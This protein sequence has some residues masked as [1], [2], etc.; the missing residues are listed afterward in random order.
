M[1]LKRRNFLLFLAG[2]TSAMP[3][4][5]AS[6]YAL[7]TLLKWG[8][9]LTM[10]FTHL[11]A[12]TPAPSDPFFAFQLINDSIPLET[13]DIEPQQQIEQHSSY[14]VVNHLLLPRGEPASG[15]AGFSSPDNL[16]NNITHLWSLTDTSGG[17]SSLFG[18]NW[19]WL[20]S[21]SGF[22]AGKA[23]LFGI[24]PLK[25][26][27]TSSCF[28]PDS[29]TRLL[30][31]QYPKVVNVIRQN[32]VLEVRILAITTTKGKEFSQTRQMPFGFN[33]FSNSPNTL[34]KPDAVAIQRYCHGV[35]Q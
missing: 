22:K 35:P 21:I 34:P 2:D 12:Q 27:T 9:K 31:I 5:R 18:N 26:E 28:T 13:S 1:K 6:S 23:L 19:V 3:S 15:K 10:P 29:H 16:V 32:K 14:E 8:E 25:C 24:E 20:I 7:C 33:W 30:S 17:K 11:A 4:A